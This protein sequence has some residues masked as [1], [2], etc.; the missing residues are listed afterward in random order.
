MVPFPAR[1]LLCAGWDSWHE[2]EVLGVEP[3]PGP[4]SR[5]GF[6]SGKA[7]RKVLCSQ[8]GPVH[9]SLQSQTQSC[10][11]ALSW[12]HT[13]ACSTCPQGAHS[14]V[15]PRDSWGA[16]ASSGQAAP[17]DVATSSASTSF[18]ASLLQSMPCPR[19]G[20]Y[21]CQMVCLARNLL[22]LVSCRASHWVMAKVSSGSLW[23]RRKHPGKFCWFVC[24]SFAE[25]SAQLWSRYGLP[26][27]SASLLGYKKGRW[28][29]K[30]TTHSMASGQS[31]S[32]YL[33]RVPSEIN[34][35]QDPILSI[36]LLLYN[37]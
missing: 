1:M 32:H 8:R 16:A 10:C 30:I 6:V 5:C 2:M 21:G 36:C 13:G 12:L 35:L 33:Q 18:Q 23:K 37:L 25:G 7:Q 22:G 9:L 26:C 11:R 20:L 31:Q 24:V 19:P 14:P 15:A 34:G 27:V 4:A 17:A 3:S 29:P 28:E